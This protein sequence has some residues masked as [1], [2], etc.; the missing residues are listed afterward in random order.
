MYIS[1]D[2]L[3]VNC[4]FGWIVLLIVIW[5]QMIGTVLYSAL[6]VLKY[7]LNLIITFN[8]LLVVV[9]SAEYLLRKIVC[10]IVVPLY[11]VFIITDL[12]VIILRC[13]VSEKTV[14][15]FKI[16]DLILLYISIMTLYKILILLLECWFKIRRI[17]F[18]WFS[19][20][21]P[22]TFWLTVSN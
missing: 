18:L 17:L 15:L 16:F 5:V 11:A 13:R 9:T 14:R 3:T 10:Y 8:W 22:Y 1:S 20:C 6:S 19:I 4:S 21:V 12:I 7:W 2:I